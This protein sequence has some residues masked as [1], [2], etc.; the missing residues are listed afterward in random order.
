MNASAGIF[1]AAVYDRRKA[2]GDGRRSPLHRSAFTLL[3]LLVV[4]GIIALIAGGLGFALG[5]TSGNSLASAQNTVVGLIN[6]ART[7]AAV[8]QT[9]AR[10][11][12]YATR[13][14]ADTNGYFLRQLRVVVAETPGLSS[15]RWRPVGAAVQ[16]PRGIFVVPASTTGL[17][18]AGVAWPSG[19]NPPVSNLFTAASRLTIVD[20]AAGPDTYFYV[21]FRS[22]GSLGN[23]GAQS[24]ASLALSGATA[25]N[26]LPQFTNA[27]AV[28]GAIIRANGAVT[29]ANDANAF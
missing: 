6:T 8:Q 2:P 11:L 17:V 16:L 18:A 1:V 27:G 21:E 20:D 3:E 5:D 19:S 23:L 28:R 29:A 26:N 22:D 13:P 14:P 25:A 9:E 15:T 24:Y 10:L 7:Q 12:V 4:I